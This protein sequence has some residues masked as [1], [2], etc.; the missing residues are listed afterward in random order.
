[1][2]MLEQAKGD[3]LLVDDEPEICAMLTDALGANGYR[4][5]AVHGGKSALALLYRQPFDV[6]VSDIAMPDMNGLDLLDKVRVVR[7]ES[8]V[9]LIT[10]VG[11]TNWARQALRRGAFDFIEKP[12]DL[13]E[14]RSVVDEALAASHQQAAATPSSKPPMRA[15][16]AEPALEYDALTGLLV[17]RRF[18]EELAHLRAR[19]RRNNRPLTVLLID[20]D[21]FH[22]INASCGHGF[23]DLV[24]HE[25]AEQLRSICRGSDILARYQWDTFAVALPDT[26]SN[27][28]ATFAERCRA[29]L[30]QTPLLL[31]GATA[32]VTVSIGLAECESGFIESESHL[33]ARAMEALREAKRR[34]KNQLVR[35]E[36]LHLDSS[37]I[38]QAQPPIRLAAEQ[39]ERLQQQLKQ[40][41][42]ESTR[43]LVAAV[44]AKDPYTRQ[45][46]MTVA[47]YSEALG[48]EL[49]LEPDQIDLC[50]TAA[51]LHDI[52][53]IGIPDALLT[54]PGP[55]T[56]AEADLIKRHP[57]VSVQILEHI[58]FLKSELPAILH[59][60]ERYDGRGYP[61]GLAGE[62]I[63]LSARILHVA[64]ATDA[65]FS[66]RSY[67]PGYELERVL[68]ELE[69]GQGSQFDPQIAATMIEWLKRNPDL[70]IRPEQREEKL[71][72]AG[73]R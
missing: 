64:D 56:P 71:A 50:K 73:Y 24:L 10:G 15:R 31:D 30:S 53:K 22:A 63:P 38:E 48:R 35:W 34:G 13:T 61:A 25:L 43:A 58:S 39:L 9:I 19:C 41:C 28:A 16:P 14:I 2:A 21:D 54:K 32:R 57:M 68:A 6:I 42:L 3:I 27:G 69:S 47:F 7:P 62:S 67:K 51:I 65:M 11:S 23:G 36:Q 8:K 55:L 72:A 46:S 26:D 52:G 45:H 5:T 44:E 40:T 66:Q 49:G 37:L 60:H 12:F 70:I 18:C 1:M 59:H 20:V 4:C 29:T 33:L 17:H